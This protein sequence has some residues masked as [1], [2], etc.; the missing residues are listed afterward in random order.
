MDLNRLSMDLAAALEDA[1]RLATRAGA[2][3][4]KP[5]HLLTALLQ[6][7]GALEHIATPAKLDAAMAARFVDQ[8]PDAGNEGSLESGKQ[9]IA[10]R[11]LRDLF[12]RSFAVADRRGGRTVGPIEV[13][14]AAAESPGLQVGQALVDA[15]W[16]RDK[17]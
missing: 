8:V 7:G 2:A 10:S 9:P 15:G 1:R 12:D 5:K 17:L 3:Y 13:A 4:I 11:A 6:K 16:S 14:L